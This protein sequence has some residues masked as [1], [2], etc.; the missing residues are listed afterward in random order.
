M[1]KSITHNAIVLRAP[2]G[3]R[4]MQ[5]LNGDI[6]LVFQRG[7]ERVVWQWLGE[8]MNNYIYPEVQ[9]VEKVT[10]PTPEITA[11]RLQMEAAQAA[12]DAQQA[13]LKQSPNDNLPPLEPY[14][15]HGIM[16]VVEKQI[17]DAAAAAA[18]EHGDDP[19]PAYVIPT[20]GP[21]VYGPNGP[22]AAAEIAALP[23]KPGADGLYEGRPLPKS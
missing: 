8:W 5:M 16:D 13:S 7:R 10:D 21:I 2:P 15:S 6:E 9:R 17:A 12:H 3:A 23:D 18:A 19:R 22:M 14:T 11:L 1:P 4:F 20:T